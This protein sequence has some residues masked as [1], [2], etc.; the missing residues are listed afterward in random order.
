MNHP[1]TSAHIPLSLYGDS[2]KVHG[3]V[4]ILGVFLGIPVWRPASTRCSRW[5]L[6]ALEESRMWGRETLD[7]TFARITY[8]LNLLID[9]WDG[10]KELCGS[11]RFACTE[12]KGDWLWHKQLWSF[13][14]AWTKPM[15]VCYRCTAKARSTVDSDLFWDVDNG[16]WHEYTKLEFI[17]EQL[18]HLQKPCRSGVVFS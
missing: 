8:S 10:E 3:G 1:A 5:L 16:V 14:S 18:G 7:A 11:R 12:L 17:V 13:F 6:C 9:A 2:C 4:K 15:N